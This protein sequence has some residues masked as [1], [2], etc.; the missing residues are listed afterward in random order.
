MGRVDRPVLLVASGAA[1]ALALPPVGLW[2]LA[3]VA[4]VPLWCRV[5]QPPAPSPGRLATDGLLWGLGFYGAGLS[6]IT[7]LHPLTWLGLPWLGS[8]ATALAAWGVITMW[9][10]VTP[11]MWA[12]GMGWLYGQGVGG[13]LG[14]LVATALWW[15]LETLRNYSPLDWLPLGLTQSPH[16][17]ALLHLG[18]LAGPGAITAV[19]VVANGLL[20]EAWTSRESHSRR[21]YLGSLVALV[22][23]AHGIGGGLLLRS[24]SLAASPALDPLTLGIVQGNV[25]TR[26]KLTP[27]GI[28]QSA[29]R[30][31]GGYAELAQQGVAAVITPEG[32]LPILWQPTASL[33]RQVTQ[34]VITQGVPLWLGTFNPQAQRPE[35][36]YTQSLLELTPAGMRAE[37]QKRQLVPL[38]EYIP[39]Q[40]LLGGVINRLS[41]LDS[42]LTPGPAVQRFESTLGPVAVGICYESAYSRLFRRQVRQGGRFIVTTSNNDPYPPWM[43]TQHHALDVMRAVETHRWAV[44]VTN[45]GLSALVDSQGRTLWQLPPRTYALQIAQVYSQQDQ[46]LYTRWGDWLGPTLVVSAGL[47]LLTHYWRQ[48]KG[49]P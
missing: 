12:V 6:W 39:L 4:L 29:E 45:T 13:R 30:Y 28:R 43:M 27:A 8:V 32:A 24:E 16:N 34:A 36:T 22:V 42:Y 15:V 26:E 11:M 41:P 38:G 17:L 44:R 37:Y 2:P 1:M 33:R 9:G 19:L 49:L 14:L 35:L 46:T 3:W 23:V 40:G 31:L 48:T 25:P 7:A 47:G 18:Q 21:A 5:K 10:A 20:S